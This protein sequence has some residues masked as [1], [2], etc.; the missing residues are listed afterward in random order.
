MRKSEPLASDATIADVYHCIARAESVIT[1][2]DIAGVVDRSIL[3]IAGALIN[4]TEIGAIE[5]HTNAGWQVREDFT[6]P[7]DK[8]FSELEKE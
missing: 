4:L 2:R 8:K 1:V 5:Y 3:A 6:W 7:I